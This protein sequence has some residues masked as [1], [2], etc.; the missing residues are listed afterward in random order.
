MKI[1]LRR[2]LI[3]AQIGALVAIA[4]TASLAEVPNPLPVAFDIA[5]LRPLGA[6]QAGRRIGRDGPGNHSLYA[7][8]NA[9]RFRSRGLSRGGRVAPDRSCE[10]R[11][12]SAARRGL[13]RLVSRARDAFSVAPPR[14]AHTNTQEKIKNGPTRM[15]TRLLHYSLIVAHIPTSSSSVKPAGGNR[16]AQAVRSRQQAS[17]TKSFARNGMDTP[18]SMSGR[19]IRY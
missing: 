5:V 7:T 10:L 19:L 12:S 4:P 18:H 3:S 6:V 13:R 16:T 15:P 11:V 14:A 2:F 1:V 9:V 17:R 8:Q